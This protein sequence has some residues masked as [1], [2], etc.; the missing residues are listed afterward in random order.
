VAATSDMTS[1][2]AT[3]IIP[4]V[5]YAAKSTQDRH[6]SIPTQLDDCREK[7]AAEGWTCASVDEFHDEGFSAYSGNRGNGLAQAKARAV[8]L[9]REHG[10]CM[11]VA[12]AA[13]RFARGSGDAPGAADALVEIWHQLRRQGVEL[14]S[15]ED[16][17]DLRDSASVANLGHRAHMDSRR[18]SNSIKKGHARRRAK[19]MHNGGPRKLGYAYARHADAS[20]VK[21]A[22]LRVVPAEAEVVRR[23]FRD[24]VAGHSQRAIARTLTAEKI[25]TARGGGWYQG[26]IAKLL[27]DPF[28]AGLV[29]DGDTLVPGQHEAIIELELYQSA[30]RIRNAGQ[31]SLHIGGRPPSRPYLFTNGYL[32]C[33]RCGGAMIPRTGTQK[34]GPDGTPWGQRYERYICHTR[35]RDVNACEQPPVSRAA[36]DAA[37]LRTLARRGVSVEQTRAQLLTAIAAERGHVEARLADAMRQERRAADSLTRVRRDYMSGGLPLADWNTMRPELEE[38]LEGARA[39]RAQVERRFAALS[40]DQVDDALAAT[41]NQLTAAI[42]AQLHDAGNVDHV[43]MLLRRMFAHFTLRAADDE[44]VLVPELRPDALEQ[45]LSA[46]HRAALQLKTAYDALTT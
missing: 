6:L 26:T 10:R 33:G 14:R 5:H 24:Y 19:G 31:R 39:A 1:A 44:L 23:I 4:A 29:R 28:Y 36:V 35:T 8:E 9:A 13:D 34:R 42:A 40:D 41:V 12:Q 3:P 45:L 18:K 16:D 11:L 38:E 46:E 15:A 7:S 25:Q 27:A 43:R 32:R 37:A 2:R 17:F 20:T 22:P 21:D 30:E